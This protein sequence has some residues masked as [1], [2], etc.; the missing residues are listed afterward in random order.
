MYAQWTPS[1]TAATTAFRRPIVRAG[2]ADHRISIEISIAA[3]IP[4]HL[5]SEYGYYLTNENGDLIFFESLGN[6]NFHT[7]QV[8]MRYVPSGV[9]NIFAFFIANG[10]ERT[11]VPVMI[12]MP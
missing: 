1:Q 12:I 10:E 7:R 11:S 9:Y 3:E 4:L 8:E 5:I 6:P 2:G